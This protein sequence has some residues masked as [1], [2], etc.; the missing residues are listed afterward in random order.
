MT[1]IEAAGGVAYAFPNLTLKLKDGL[2]F[3]V[4]GIGVAAAGA[5]SSVV[6]IAGGVDFAAGIIGVENISA[7]GIASTSMSSGAAL[8]A[9]GA[10][11]L[12][13]A[14]L[15]LASINVSSG[16]TVNAG[17]IGLAADALAGAA[18]VA[19]SS[20]SFITAGGIGIHAFAIGNSSVSVSSGSFVTALGIGIE[21]DGIGIVEVKN[22][23]Q[24]SA[25]GIGID[26]HSVGDVIIKTGETGT[27]DVAR[28]AVDPIGINV[29]A[30]GNTLIAVSGKIQAVDGIGNGGHGV[31]SE[32]SGGS[33]KSHSIKVSDI[34]A[35]LDGIRAT[36]TGGASTSIS[37]GGIEA[38]RDAIWVDANSGSVSVKVASTVEA[39][40][41]AVDVTA[42]SSDVSLTIENVGKLVASSDAVL[43]NTTGKVTI[44]Q[45]GIITSTDGS[46]INVASAGDAS[47]ILE[48]A[49]SAGIDGVNVSGS[50]TVAVDQSSLAPIVALQDGLK[51]GSSGGPVSITQNGTLTV[52]RD[53]IVVTGTG[54]TEMSTVTSNV[55]IIAPRNAILATNVD[56]PLTINANA[57]LTAMTGIDVSGSNAAGAVTMNLNAALIALT[58]GVRTDTVAASVLN[59]ASAASIAVASDLAVEAVN[60]PLTINNNGLV[61]GFLRL[62]LGNDTFNNKSSLSWYTHSAGT[63]G[64]ISAFGAGVDTLNNT[65]RIVAARDAGIVENV[66]FTGLEF[67]NNGDPTQS[68]AGLTT[69]L[70][71]AVDDVLI[72]S[73]TFNG[74]GNSMLALDAFL[75]PPGSTA[76][77]LIVGTATSGSTAIVINNTNPGPGS[78]NP[79]GIEVVDVSAGTTAPEHFY[80]AKGPIDRG[81]FFYDLLLRPDNVHVLAGLP[82][83][84]V[85]ETPRVVTATQEVWHQTASVWLDRQSDLRMQLRGNMGQGV[86]SGLWTQLIGGWEKRKVTQEFSLYNGNYSFDVGYQQQIYGFMSGIDFGREELFGLNDAWLVGVLGGYLGSRVDF[87]AT[88]TAV[89][90]QGGTVGAYF[91][92]L[93]QVYFM[94]ALVK[95]DFLKLNYVAPSLQPF[96][97]DADAPARSIGARIDSGFRVPFGATSFLDPLATLSYV[98]T[99]IGNM[100]LGGADVVYG[101]NDS[102]RGRL[103]LRA[104]GQ[105]L[106]AQGFRAEASLTASV[107]QEFLGKNEVT[108][109]SAGPDFVAT[110]SFNKT[111]FEVS[112][113][114]D[115]IDLGGGFSG[116][117]KG[118][119]RFADGLEYWAG[120]VNGG[121]RYRW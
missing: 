21:A 11:I 93:N 46:A 6:L 119:F 43:I 104:G 94:D 109:V 2:I 68:A 89:K 103:G 116:H 56:G 19:V 108:I 38:G 60:G 50:G 113:T 97:D 3:A 78:Y 45:E 54:G 74:V 77:R 10:G 107:W 22:D 120:K 53:A 16:S 98:S 62:S 90:N 12:T 81:M 114:I 33:D 84:E 121:V 5:A 52:G 100:E 61:T 65:G 9:T 41:N 66:Q 112:G 105:L 99:N 27:I 42:T 44:D 80:L 40:E 71:G 30:S 82:D 55:A 117:L 85:F 70:D 23:G 102:L 118:D 25:V 13:Q 95:A 8:F 28:L 86:G 15:G 47:L 88:D 76:D 110:D 14:G 79:V 57:A 32:N 18:S 24:I 92:Y 63:A 51:A 39:G 49:L 69:L 115:L 64:S 1:A 36:T 35:D 7:A 72:T 31:V 96:D 20:G 73:G 111:F 29:G 101:D 75:G 26:A 91:T 17:G 67:F 87:N 37:V 34:E 83:Q 58:A 4:P 59:I 48:A 106:R